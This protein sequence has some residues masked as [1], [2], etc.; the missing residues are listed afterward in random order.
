MFSLEGPPGEIQVK[1]DYT[2]FAGPR[3]NNVANNLDDHSAGKA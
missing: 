3:V 1:R 2:M